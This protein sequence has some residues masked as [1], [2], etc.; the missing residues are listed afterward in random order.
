MSLCLNYVINRSSNS[1]R[2]S[3][4]NKQH[5]RI[6]CVMTKHQSILNN[7]AT[8]FPVGK[9]PWHITITVCFINRLFPVCLFSGESEKISPVTSA[10]KNLV[11]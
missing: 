11:L 2:G 9:F 3:L 5:S 8:I 6:I 7:P 4:D 10:D 1:N